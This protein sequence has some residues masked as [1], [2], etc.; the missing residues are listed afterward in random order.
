IP[1]PTW[2]TVPTSA[3]SVSTS[4][5]SIRCLRIDVISSGRSFTGSPSGRKGFLS[6]AQRGDAASAAVPVLVPRAHD[7]DE[8]PSEAAPRAPQRRGGLPV[9]PAQRRRHRADDLAGPLDDQ[10]DA[11]LP[12]V[13]R[14]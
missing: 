6:Q 9:H 5:S 8:R 13:V 1:S 10:L 4:Y 2:S 7:K 3:R 14:G 11:H 12:A